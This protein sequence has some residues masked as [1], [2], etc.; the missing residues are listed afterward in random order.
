M[1]QLGVD[2]RDT[3]DF[4]RYW[5]E[6]WYPIN[7]TWAGWVRPSDQFVVRQELGPLKTGMSYT[8]SFK[9]R[10][11]GI[12]E[13][14]ATV[15]ILGAAENVAKKFQRNERGAVKALK[16]ETKEEILEKENFTS[17]DAWKTVEKTFVLNFKE[18]GLKQLAESTLAVLE[19]KFTLPQY[20]GHCDISDVQ[21]VAKPVK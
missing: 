2:G 18:R 4:F 6:V 1:T 19:F 16:D 3:E 11:K 12:Q 8:F 21:L 20:A 10:G 9:V 13:G 15:A 14:V 17:S 7:A 5:Y